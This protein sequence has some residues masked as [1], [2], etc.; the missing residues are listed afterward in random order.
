[1]NKEAETIHSFKYLIRPNIFEESSLRYEVKELTFTE[2][3][4]DNSKLV[5]DAKQHQFTEVLLDNKIM[6][7]LITRFLADYYMLGSV[8]TLNGKTIPINKT[9]TEFSLVSSSD[10][11]NTYKMPRTMNQVLES[12]TRAFPLNEEISSFTIIVTPRSIEFCEIA[13]TELD[14]FIDNIEVSRDGTLFT[15]SNYAKI[16]RGKTHVYLTQILNS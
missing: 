14:L 15:N 8:T 12:V 11:L 3:E 5:K 7:N 6:F 2:N 13:G 1:M 10:T 16:L 4:D 9:L